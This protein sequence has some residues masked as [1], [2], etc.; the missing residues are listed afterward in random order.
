MQVFDIFDCDKSGTIDKTEIIQMIIATNALTGNSWEIQ[1]AESFA[2]Q[3]MESCDT[4]RIGKIKKT[5][6]IN[7]Y[8]EYILLCNRNIL[9]HCSC[10]NVSKYCQLLVPGYDEGMFQYK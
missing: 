1:D 5:E 7:G 2:K 4:R 8:I 10:K 6:F 3:I 9:V